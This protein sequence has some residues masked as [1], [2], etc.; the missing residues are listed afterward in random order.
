[1]SLR[2]EYKINLTDF[3]L[4]IL[5]EG[6]KQLRAQRDCDAVSKTEYKNILTSLERAEYKN[7]KEENNG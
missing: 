7:R 4:Q 2:K 3:Q 1:M 5:R 6:I